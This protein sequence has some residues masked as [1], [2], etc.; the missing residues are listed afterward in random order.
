MESALAGDP[1]ECPSAIYPAC[2]RALAKGWRAGVLIVGCILCSGVLLGASA[3]LGRGWVLETVGEL[4]E[5]PAEVIAGARSI[6]GTY[7]GNGS[8]Q[9]YLRTDEGSVPLTPGGTYRVSFRYKVLADADRGF[10]VLFYSPKAG[11]AGSFLP[12]RFI[13]DPAGTTGTVELTNTL[14]AYDDYGARW[15]IVGRGAIAI[16]DIQL[17]EVA[18]GRVLLTENAEGPAASYRLAQSALPPAQVGRTFAVA[19]AALG[20]KPPYTWRPGTLPLP[21]GLRLESDGHLSGKVTAAGDHAF[22][23]LVTDARQATGRLLLRLTAAN[24]DPLPPPPSLAIENNT[25]TVRPQPYLPAFRNPL[26]GMRP[27]LGPARSHPFASLGRQYIEWNL[28]ENSAADTV[29]KIRAV[30][31]RL[32]GDLPS[33]NIKI[34]PRVYLHWPDRGKYWPADLPA[35]DYTSP[36][37]RARMKRLIARLG[38]AWDGDPRIAYIEAGLIGYWGE[39]HHPNFSQLPVGMEAEFGE[40]YR[41]AFPNKKIMR[42]YPRDLTSYGFGLIWDVFG[43]F[44]TGGF[45]AN[46]TTPMT[47]ELELPLHVDQWKTSPRGGEIDPTFLGESQ[48]NEAALRSVVR[49][50]TPRLVE[51]ARRLHW[52]HLA[53]LSQVDRA[54][55]D[56]WDK[57]SQIQNALGYRF[58]ISKAAHS[59]VVAPG[60]PLKLKVE[61]TNTGSSPFYYAWPLEVALADA[62]TRK[63]V[64][65]TLWDGVDL[66]TWLPGEP[67]AVEGSFALPADLSAGHYVVTLAILDPS[68]LVPAARFA[69]DHYWMGG[70]TPLGPVAVG[71][72]APTAHLNEFDDLQTDQSLYYLAPADAGAAPASSSRLSNLSVLTSIDQPGGGFTLGYVVG[73]SGTSGS[74]SLVVRTVGPSLRAFGLTNAVADPK[75]EVFSGIQKVGENDN[76]GGA[77]NLARAMSAVGAFPLAGADSRD[78]AS[79]LARPG[80]MTTVEISAAGN[81]TG[82]ILAEIYDATPAADF[83]AATPRLVNMSVLKPLGGGFSLG[84]VVAGTAPKSVL[85]RA[86][87]PTLQ[88]HFGVTD[89][90]GDPRLTLQRGPSILAAND[91]WGGDTAVGAASSAVGAF[92]LPG[93]S[94]DAALVYGV[95]PG[96]HTVAVSDGGG[97]GGRILV[98]VYELP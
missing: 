21:P 74:K 61:L 12:S 3:A 70:R 38:E 92:A 85:I 65:R 69:V 71:S 41:T 43:A 24:A 50:H 26:G 80:G 55:A 75:F 56:L 59:A 96:N 48:F 34:I 32:V 58:V 62:R 51:L 8:Y 52:N 11:A 64:W 33:Y 28:I 95:L 4:T 25:V 91:N 81:G 30:T 94:R 49:Q 20:G 31:D 53:V 66:R 63:V 84:F 90:V 68:G 46:D 83:T 40:A 17:I 39:H 82:A 9:V 93:D 22:D 7:S 19:L 23:A 37:F 88:T 47:R 10:E 42:R 67:I 89:A 45:Y 79:L 78:A 86:I 16:D 36:A 18:T 6:K 2:T 60:G 54:D 87:G 29:D 72:P 5:N 35:D 73:G 27:S 44:D 13:R 77:E 1:V 14:G 97:A 15:N 76:W 57:A 98:E